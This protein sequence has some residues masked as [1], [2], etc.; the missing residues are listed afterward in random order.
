MLIVF[1]ILDF[2]IIEFLHAKAIIKYCLLSVVQMI[3]MHFHIIH[4]LIML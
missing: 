2:G 1:C 4:L 3:S